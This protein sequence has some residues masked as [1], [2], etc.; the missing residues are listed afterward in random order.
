MGVQKE[1]KTMETHSLEK[2][3]VFIEPEIANR[4][5]F[6]KRRLARLGR[7]IYALKV[8]LDTFALE[9]V[10]S[11][12]TGD[13]LKADMQRLSNRVVHVLVIEG[14]SVIANVFSKVGTHTD[15]AEC[16]DASL[17]YFFARHRKM[18]SK[19]VENSDVYE[20]RYINA[21]SSPEE[22]TAWAKALFNGSFHR[23][24]GK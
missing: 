21:A 23:I 3:I 20:P 4:E 14:H 24:M 7:I 9:S 11:D 18:R 22:V 8:K 16:D 2:T 1:R 10:H 13:L 15:P 19:V 17:R 5:K 6:I 12:L